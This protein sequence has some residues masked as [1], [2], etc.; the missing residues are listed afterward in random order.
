VLRK[1]L[2]AKKMCFIGFMLNHCNK[3]GGS[4]GSPDP[5]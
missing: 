5:N 4:K 3:K 1:R 2:H